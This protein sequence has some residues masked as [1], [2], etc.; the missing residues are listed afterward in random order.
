MTIHSALSKSALSP[1]LSMWVLSLALY[2][3]NQVMGEVH[4]I[5]PTKVEK[6]SGVWVD[7]QY[8]GYVKELKGNKKVLLLPGEHQIVVRQAGYRDFTQSVVVE[9][10]QTLDVNIKMAKDTGVEYARVTGEIKLQ[11][12][13]DR[14]A[15]FLD[16]AFGHVHDFGGFKRA[17]LVAPG[18]HHIKVAL[19]G[20]QAFDTDV[21][22]LPNQKVTIKTDLAPGSITQAGPSIKKD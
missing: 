3:Q 9:P 12:T 11:A 4:C 6:S 16:G 2:A 19:P 14:A 17:M 13:P 15:V 10:G 8:V 20:Y 1:C 21:D 18:K 22:L 5:G 7:D